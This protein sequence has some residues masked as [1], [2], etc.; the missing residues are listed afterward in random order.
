[1]TFEEALDR[2]VDPF[3]VNYAWLYLKHMPCHMDEKALLIVDTGKSLATVLST[4]LHNYK[5]QLQRVGEPDDLCW[6]RITSLVGVDD[7]ASHDWRCGTLND[8][9][10]WTRGLWDDV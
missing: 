7:L 2:S 5:E 10:Q 1:M 8:M 3:E 9:I 6:E 4:G